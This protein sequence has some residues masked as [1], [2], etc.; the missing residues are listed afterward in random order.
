MGSHSHFYQIMIH[1]HFGFIL[2]P[3]SFIIIISFTCCQGISDF[4][5]FGVMPFEEL[6]QQLSIDGY[7]SIDKNQDSSIP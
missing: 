7:T 5:L 1:F 3:S 6:L 4:F 2:L